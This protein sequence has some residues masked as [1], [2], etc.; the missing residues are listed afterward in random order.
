MADVIPER[1]RR[2][3]ERMG[4]TGHETRAYAA[5]L[6]A[7]TAG[8]TASD[9]SGAAGIPQSKIYDVLGSLEK[10]GWL[11]AGGSRPTRYHAKSPA[12][13]IETARRRADAEFADLGRIVLSDLLPMYE[14][15]GA[16][17][18][19]EIWFLSG[20]TSIAAKILEMVDTCSSD[21]RI[22][23]PKAGEALVRQALPKLRLLRERG[24]DVT[25]LAS[26][27]I[28]AGSLKALSRVVSSV[29]TRDGLFA[30]G[31]I[32]DGRYVV[33]LLGHEMGESSS[34]GTLAIWAD[35]AG[36]A[37]F[38]LEYFEYLLKDSE[39]A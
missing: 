11:D 14:R 24:V 30:G 23:V 1:A 10:K 36:L 39:G 18:R 38:A 8:T 20:A 32:A 16:S 37:G 34:A 22:A 17:E 25:V 7:G 12:T 33:I 6:G 28:S 21:V 5:L 13:G 15:S 9:L 27:G 4:L 19:P 26:G 35:H 2:A 29:R 31:I 3:L